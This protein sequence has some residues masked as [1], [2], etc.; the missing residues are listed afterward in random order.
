MESPDTVAVTISAGGT[1]EVNRVE[2][3]RIVSMSGRPP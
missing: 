1:C 3:W 2:D